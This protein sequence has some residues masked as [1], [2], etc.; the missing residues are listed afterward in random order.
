[1]FKYFSFH[2]FYYIKERLNKNKTTL[3]CENSA[4]SLESEGEKMFTF[5]QYLFQHLLLHT[6]KNQ[7]CFIKIKIMSEWLLTASWRTTGSVCLIAHLTV[8][9]TFYK[10]DTMLFHEKMA[11]NRQDVKKNLQHVKEM[12][13][14]M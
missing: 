12:S 11:N 13:N 6:N 10:Q 9:S 5:M 14:K 8:S 2:T 3:N 4:M 1:M 7:K